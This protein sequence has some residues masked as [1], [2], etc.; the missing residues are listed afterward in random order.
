MPYQKMEGDEIGVSDGPLYGW[1]LSPP[2][3]RCWWYSYPRRAM[4]YGAPSRAGG[5]M[6]LYQLTGRFLV[7]ITNSHW[8][9]DVQI[10]IVFVY[11]FEILWA[12]DTRFV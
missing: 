11:T 1:L 9:A 6:L 12:Q 2:D 7:K 4:L 3:S 8:L 10:L 5:V